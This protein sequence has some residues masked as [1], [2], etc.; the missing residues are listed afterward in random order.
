MKTVEELNRNCTPLLP[1][2]SEGIILKGSEILSK[3]LVLNP[4]LKDLKLDPNKNYE[5]Y[6]RHNKYIDW[7]LNYS[8]DS[9]WLRKH[10][11]PEGKEK[12][13]VDKIIKIYMSDPDYPMNEF[14]YDLIMY[15]YELKNSSNRS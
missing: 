15:E 13:I 2:G 7:I 3:G 8:S 4:V 14:V 12:E 9:D 5:V 11:L 1:E 10:K 6:I